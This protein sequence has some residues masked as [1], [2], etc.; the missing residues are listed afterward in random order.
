MIEALAFTAVLAF[1]A[2]VIW[3]AWLSRWWVKRR[4]VR[5]LLRRPPGSLRQYEFDYLVQHA[6]PRQKQRW[7]AKHKQAR[8]EVSTLV[9]EIVDQLRKGGR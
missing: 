2:W 5:H 3:P 6:T 8:E 1:W 4:M 7:L 9:T